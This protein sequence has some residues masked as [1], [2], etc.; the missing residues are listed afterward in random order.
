MKC[1]VVT[2]IGPGHTD[3]YQNQ[4]VPT[5]QTAYE[6]GSGAF[7][8]V[9]IIPVDDTSGTLGRSRAR[10][11]GVN[12][13]AK[14]NCDWIFFLDADDLL[15]SM[16]FIAVQN[17]L[18]DLDGIWGQI[19]EAPYSDLDAVKVRENQTISI[20]KY[21]DLLQIDPFYS[22]QMGHF[23]KVELASEFPFN[24]DLNTGEDFDYY[25]RI[26]NKYNCEKVDEI[27]FINVRGNHSTGP[28][29]ANGRDWRINVE[30][31]ISEAR[32]K[33]K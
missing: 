13:A 24:E 17:Y 7:E 8:D 31:L 10:N 1:G 5:I 28:K 6:T 14:L 16:A 18:K 2:P 30:K 32:A 12:E 33:S 19:V 29:S 15:H 22:L 27:F 4:C 26:W 23:V 25:L 21:N 9:V 20:R 3:T 11:I